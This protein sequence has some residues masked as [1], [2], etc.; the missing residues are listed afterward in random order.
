MQC[1]SKA[2]SQA[3]FYQHRQS[4]SLDYGYCPPTLKLQYSAA[5]ICATWPNIL[6]APMPRLS[7]SGHCLIICCRNR[8]SRELA[9]DR[10]ITNFL[11]HEEMAA[12]NSLM[13]GMRLLPCTVNPAG[14]K[15]PTKLQTQGVRTP[16]LTPTLESHH[17]SLTGTD[18]PAGQTMFLS[19]VKPRRVG[20]TWVWCQ[21]QNRKYSDFTP[22]LC[23]KPDEQTQ[24]VSAGS[25]ES[26]PKGNLE[27]CLPENCSL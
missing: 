17:A 20:P 19:G 2:I 8:F 3:L 21:K 1:G 27:I 25:S 26:L 5:E 9:K 16:F 7:A 14:R 23:C 18:M 12:A 13:G 11:W 6:F 4:T 22:F 10:S 24:S 15:I